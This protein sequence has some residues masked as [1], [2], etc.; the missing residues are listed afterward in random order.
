MRTTLHDVAN[1]AGVSAITVSRVLRQPMKV[2]PELRQRILH[3][4]EEMDYVPDLA[5]RALA[6][7]HN[8]TFGVLVPSLNDR[9]F[10]GFMH[11]VEERVRDTTY[12]IQYANT[13]NFVEEEK[14]QVRLLLSQNTAGIVLGGLEGIESVAE[15]ISRASCSVVQ[16]VDVSLNVAGTCVALDHLE[17]AATATR[18]LIGCGYRR[19]AILGGALDERA[20]RRTEGYSQVMKQEGLYDPALVQHENAATSTQMGSR[21]LR[22]ALKA[23]PDIDAVFCQSD[24]IALGALFEAQRLGKRVPEE[25][26][27]CG[28]NDLDFASVMEPPLTTIRTPLFEMGYRTADLL[29]RAAEGRRLEPQIVNLGYELIERR[30]T[31][32]R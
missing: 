6:S 21:L 26:G 8:F 12:R 3:I 16:V 24:D 10:L 22:R 28:Y 5:A 4:I 23:A 9:A 14:R 2:S 18:H 1:K 11:G 19:I 30:T 25:F 7:R 20:R 17:A 13:H 32:R 29:I 27:I 15:L 31:R